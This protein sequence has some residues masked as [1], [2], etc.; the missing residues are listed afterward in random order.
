MTLTVDVDE[1]TAPATKVVVAVSEL[2]PVGE[3]MVIVLA[4]ALVDS[5]VQVATPT[6]LVAP[7]LKVFELPVELR[8]GVISETAIE[9][10]S[11]RVTV[12]VEV[13]VPSAV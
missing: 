4:S 9:P 5:N 10:A 1:L 2:S 8:V 6:A 13:E 7:Q 12:I 3:V 11:L